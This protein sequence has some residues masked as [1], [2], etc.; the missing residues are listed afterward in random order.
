[1][2]FF[3]GYRHTIRALRGLERERVPHQTVRS[4]NMRRQ[5]LNP[6]PLVKAASA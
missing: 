3:S 4:T 2:V 5:P 1:M 6:K